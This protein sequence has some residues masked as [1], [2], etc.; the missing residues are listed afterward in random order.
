MKITAEF[1]LLQSQM[2]LITFIYA[3]NSAPLAKNLKI[4]IALPFNYKT[5]YSKKIN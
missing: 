2:Q 5:S 3:T 1:T 4:M